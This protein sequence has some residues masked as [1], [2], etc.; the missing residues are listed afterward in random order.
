[1][2]ALAEI[3]PPYAVRIR[4]GDLSLAIVTDDDLP[5]LVALVLG[6]IHDP[7]EMPFS[8]PWTLEDPAKLPASVVRYFWRTRAEFRP[9]KFALPFAVRVAEE[10]VGV[11]EF[12]TENFTV[13]RT[14]ETGSWLGRM[15]Q[16]R[17]IGTRMRQALCAFAFF[18]LGAAEVTS[19]AFLD[20]P[21]SLAVS[22]KVGYRP[23]GRIRR[24]RRQGEVAINQRLVLT[25]QTFVRG[26]PIE[27]SGAEALRTFLDLT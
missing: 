11:Q 26:A 20:N 21:A 4:E 19:S 27:V 13:T 16:G 12:D 7:E 8:E 15:H 22:L 10:L 2:S 5:A 23:N 14:G 9:E 1:M 25:P 18:E 6:G 24:Q 17:G 3:W